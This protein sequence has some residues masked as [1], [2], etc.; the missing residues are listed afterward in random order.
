LPFRE[1]LL[2]ELLC[3]KADVVTARRAAQEAVAALQV[4]APMFGYAVA[5]VTPIG[6]RLSFMICALCPIIQRLVGVLAAW[7]IMVPGMSCLTPA[8]FHAGLSL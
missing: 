5:F 8:R 7:M 2:E 1:E 3:E 6:T 4:C